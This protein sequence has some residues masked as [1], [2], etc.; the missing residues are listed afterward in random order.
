LGVLASAFSGYLAIKYLLLL[1]EKIGYGIFFWY[2]M[3][4][5]LVIVWFYFYF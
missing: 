1:I 5:A 3:L 2:R 4:L